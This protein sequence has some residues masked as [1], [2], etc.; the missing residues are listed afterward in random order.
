MLSTV[1]HS[2][3][4]R[5]SAM[6]VRTRVFMCNFL[7]I[8]LTFLDTIKLLRDRKLPC[9]NGWKISIKR[10][11]SLWADSSANHDLKF[12]LTNRL[13]QDCLENP[14]PHKLLAAFRQTVVD[15]LLLPIEASNCQTDIDKVLLDLAS[16]SQVSAPSQIRES[17]L[18][19]E[20]LSG[21]AGESNAVNKLNIC[22]HNVVIYMA[23][24]VLRR[25]PFSR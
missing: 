19:D 23:R 13:N 11:L 2:N 16:F 22:T 25:I 17:T 6:P 14:D 9:L 4:A 3:A 15:K 24:Y 20:H 1:I 10:P 18:H 8:A 5:N 12:L 21:S 7:K